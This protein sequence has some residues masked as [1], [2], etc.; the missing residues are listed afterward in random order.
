MADF[1]LD[2]LD[3][4]RRLYV[5][6]TFTGFHWR[7]G[8]VVAKGEEMPLDITIDDRQKVKVS[9]VPDGP[10]DGIPLWSVISGNATVVP[11]ENGMGAYLV[12]EDNAPTG[13][14]M[15][16]IEV[17]ADVDLGVG[18]ILLSDHINLQV[19]EAMA[20]SLGLTASAPEPK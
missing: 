7:V 1:F 6:H 9:L 4:L 2:L 3:A 15:S 5:T 18:T 14:A 16:V 11:D 13:G 20:T 17:S 10:V 8:P 19:T 12:S